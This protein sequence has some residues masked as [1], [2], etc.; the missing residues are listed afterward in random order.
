MGDWTTF[1][2]PVTGSLAGVGSAAAIGVIDVRSGMNNVTITPTATAETLSV[3]ISQD[4]GATYSTTFL[5]FASIADATIVTALATGVTYYCMNF[6][7]CTHMK[8]TKSGAVNP[9]SLKY[10][11]N[12]I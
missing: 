7:A 11:L 6:P 4:G 1:S 12:K 5:K 9:G 8:I 2:K 3:T 10:C